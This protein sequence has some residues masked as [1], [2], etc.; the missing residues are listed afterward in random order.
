MCVKII[1]I[2]LT[3]AICVTSGNLTNFSEPYF[4]SIYKLAIKVGAISSGSC[5]ESQGKPV[6]GASHGTKNT[7]SIV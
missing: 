4:F 1:F 3:E 6:R 2:P 7:E 5:A